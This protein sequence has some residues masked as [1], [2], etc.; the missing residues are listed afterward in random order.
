MRC[1][2]IIKDDLN[3]NYVGSEMIGGLL[4]QGDAIMLL[5]NH[6]LYL[7]QISIKNMNMTIRWVVYINICIGTYIY[8]YLNDILYGICFIVTHDESNYQSAG[9]YVLQMY[10][11]FQG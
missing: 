4:N 10:R 3:C 2:T 8:I 9:L 1:P 11:S 7:F 6:K 5:K